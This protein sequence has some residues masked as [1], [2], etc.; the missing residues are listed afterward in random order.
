[1]TKTRMCWEAIATLCMLTLLFAA[2]SISAGG[3]RAALAKEISQAVRD[4]IE[5]IDAGDLDRQ[6]SFWSTDPEATSVIMG[7]IWTGVANI[8]VRSAEYVPV[9]KVM[10]NELGEIRVV[11]LG[12]DTALAVVPY[13][14][15]RRNPADE[16][17]KPFE[18]DSMLTLVWK[19][20]PEG[21]RIIHEHV[22]V[23]VP[24]PAVTQ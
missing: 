11:A 16:R 5:F 10:R 13:R 14:S 22:S 1:M 6:M 20:T 21:W 8:R 24:P 12:A 7:E 3:D 17:L 19:R 23:K 2:S 4:Y 9:S 18:L 15:V